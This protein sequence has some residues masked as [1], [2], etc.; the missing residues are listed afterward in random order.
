MLKPEVATRAVSDLQFLN[1]AGA[2]FVKTNL[3]GAR[4]YL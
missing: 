3:A 2:R 1:L 4:A